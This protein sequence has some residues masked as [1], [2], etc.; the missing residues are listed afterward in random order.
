MDRRRC[1]TSGAKF[2]YLLRATRAKTFA[3]FAPVAGMLTGQTSLAEPKP[4]V[5]ISG[6]QDHQNEFQEQ[7]A[8][9]ERGRAL[10]GATGTGT[11]CGSNC[12]LYASAKG[13]PAMTVLHQG[14]HIYP[15]NA[16][17]LIVRFFHGH[18]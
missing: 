3:A 2:V 4:F 18:P 8:S 5:H 13:A 16:T 12:L 9:V 7:L 14:G 1:R 11:A 6:R 10:N 17:A 15:G